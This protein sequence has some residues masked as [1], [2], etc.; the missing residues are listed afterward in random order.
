MNMTLGAH[1]AS[2][3]PLLACPHASLEVPLNLHFA[4]LLAVARLSIK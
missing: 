4:E 1:P 2:C 3:G